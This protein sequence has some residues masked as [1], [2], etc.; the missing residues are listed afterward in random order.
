MSNPIAFNYQIGGSLPADAPSYV[1]R[2]C[3]R[4]YY[5]LLKAANYCYVFNCRQMGKSSLRVR[6]THKLQAEG[7]T[8]ATID[9]QKIGV[10]VTCE[11]WYASAIRSLVGELN[12]KGSFDLR[13]WLREREMLSPVQRFAE[14]IEAIVLQ[15]IDTPIVIFV[16]EID[17][18]LSL[19]FGMDDFFGLVR[20]LFEDRPTKPEY[21][22]L[23]FS[24]L[25]V[26]TPTDLIQSKS[27]S[28]FNI[29][30]AV[31]MTGFT[32]EEAMPLARGLPSHNPQAYLEAAVQWT[33]GQPFLI[34]RLLGLIEKELEGTPQPENVATWVEDL[35]QRRIVTNW[36]AQDT[37]PHLMTIRDRVTSVEEKLRGRMLGCYQQVLADGELEDDRS[38]ERS[39][40][41]LTGLVVRREGKLRSY[42]PIYAAVFNQLWCDRMLADLRPEFYGSAFRA[43]QKS[44]EQKESFLLR[45]QSLVDAETWAKGK[46]LSDEDE[47]FLEASREVSKQETDRKLG[48][49]RFARETAEEANQILK[50]ANRKA[51]KR[52]R[53]GSFILV[54]MLVTAG[55]AGIRAW[56]S[57]KKVAAME[58]ARQKA[59]GQIA[60]AEV[61]L[62]SLN[63]KV[64]FLDNRGIE[65]Q[66]LALR[67]GNK[68]KLIDKNL[69]DWQE[70]KQSNIVPILQQAIYRVPEINRLGGQIV[71]ANFSP[72]GSKIFTT[73]DDNKIRTWDLKGN[74]IAIVEL[75]GHAKQLRSANFSSDGGKIITISESEDGTV[76]VWDIRGNLMTELKGHTRQVSYTNLSPDSSKIVT[77]SEDK[78]TRLWDI[79]GNQI[80]ELKGLEEFVFSVSFNPDGSKIV[81]A[82]SNSPVR[83]W[84]INGNQIAELKGHTETVWNASFSPDGS[85]IVTASSDKT[86]R[87]WDLDGNQITEFKGHTKRLLS[88]NFSPD[89][90][91]IVTT[92]DDGT[93]RIW[94][95]KGNQIDELKG[96]VSRNA[97]FSPDGNKIVTV[98]ADKR[99]RVW[100]IKGNQI[101]ELKSN[102]ALVLNANFSPDGSK[103]FTTSFEQ[104]MMGRVWDVNGN[105]IAELK[106]SFIKNFS[107]DS[108]KIITTSVDNKVSLL[109]VKGNLIAELK[110]HNGQVNSANFSPDGSKVVT[111]S[112]DK[113]AKVWD[114]K[115]NLITELNGHKD[116]VWSANFSPDGSKIVT[117]SFDKTAKVWDVK[118]NLLAELQGHLSAVDDANFSPDGAQIVTASFD[119]TGRL[120]GVK[121][122]LIAELKG[123]TDVVRYTSFSSDGSKIVTSSDD[124]TARVWDSKGN[125]I[126]ELK[127][128]INIASSA[129]FSPDGSKIVSI[130]D[131]TVQVWDVSGNLITELKGHTQNVTSANFSSD[132]SKI[133]TASVDGTARVWD[134]K[135]ESDL[136]R[137]LIL[138][139]DKLHDYLTNSAIASDDDRQMCGIEPRKK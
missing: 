7:I 97:S 54:V 139:C 120:W 108:S 51:K 88:A 137:L 42:N 130:S 52:V 132:G 41:R 39:K 123:H 59:I 34:Q 89:G 60:L 27:V 102:K 4:D 68:L 47:Q 70:I 26:A 86:A 83:V 95:T 19:K 36:E 1:E 37:P 100:N 72:D 2:Q 74:L 122:N 131:K 63:A 118:G 43:W 56:D 31:E 65:A 11:Q 28:A 135:I 99:L 30:T 22:R 48:M 55:I 25:G 20:S 71:S 119:N 93:T 94:D 73:S 12:L 105:Q 49:E 62:E 127:G 64:A 134:V 75:K 16:E 109:D 46:R 15:E 29:G 125:L 18:L 76:Q 3:D 82:S 112:F 121:G 126:A 77:T 129:S 53:I 44:E 32:L 21:N 13:S 24:F 50:E 138:G 106:S 10:E 61:N 69:T 58:E 38:E 107:P 116:I 79:N 81:T 136:N 98:S 113:T 45:S 111:A 6:V 90:S 124:K 9:P 85:K 5:E 66:L 91:K 110:G 117:A 17:R 92:S 128:D 104:S 87:L 57:N 14:F 103:I 84:D 67:A 23:T 8:C 101:A 33:G 115:G 80:T 78:T 40:L 114:V 96:N 133:V 35:V